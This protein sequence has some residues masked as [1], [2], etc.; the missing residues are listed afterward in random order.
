MEG[1]GLRAGEKMRVATDC[2]LGYGTGVEGS[3]VYYFLYSMGRRG[4]TT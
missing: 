2:C 4:Y 1:Q 3:P